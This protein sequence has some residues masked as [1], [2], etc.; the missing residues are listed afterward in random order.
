MRVAMLLLLSFAVPL[1]AWAGPAEEGNE[2]FWKGEFESAARLYRSATQAHP[3][4]ADAWYNLG[5]AEARAG[6]AGRAIYAFE[7]ARMLRPGD[8]D[9]AHNLEQV[10]AWA[11]SE[12]L[13]SSTDER[14]VLPGDDDLGVGLLT[15]LKPGTLAVGFAVAWVLLFGLLGMA[16]RLRHGRRTAAWFGAVLAGLASVAFGAL[17]WGRAS[18]LSDLRQGVVVAD[19]SR[20]RSGPGEQY[21]AEAILTG[22]VLVRL[23]GEVDGWNRVTL[24]DGGEGWIAAADLGAL[25]AP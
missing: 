5:C 8:A 19:R 6:R 25:E 16:H 20:V 12:A 17:L 11:V 24:P 15:A 14:L 7:Q 21:K 1:A 23:R 18:L 10:R 9:A 3:Q 4:S 22:G 13:A 2:A